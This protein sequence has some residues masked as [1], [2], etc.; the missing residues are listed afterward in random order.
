MVDSLGGVKIEGNSFIE[1]EGVEEGEEARE[2]GL[3]EERR[4]WQE[5]GRGRDEVEADK[6]GG[7]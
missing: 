4:C 6:R 1:A 2:W 3:G 7:G 5:R